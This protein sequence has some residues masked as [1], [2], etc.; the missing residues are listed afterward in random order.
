MP[1]AIR[2]FVAKILLALLCCAADFAKADFHI[3]R[4]AEIEEILTEIA[5]SVFKVA[6]INPESAKVYVVNS[7]DINAFTIGGG[8]VFVTSG[9][10]LRFKDPLYFLGVLCHETG[11]M[12]ARHIDR[13]IVALQNRS[14]NIMLAM[15][16]GLLGAVAGSQEAL[17]LALGYVVTDERFYLRYS[18]GDEFAADALGASYL[19]KLGYGSDVMIEVFSEFQRM[20]ILNGEASLPVYIRTHPKSNDR[21]SALQ[22]RAKSKKF[23]A[24]EELAKK[25]LRVLIKLNAYLKR[26]DVKTLVPT[27]D[28]SKAIYLH[29]IG[30]S[31]EA[32]DILRKLLKTNPNDF[33][34]QETLAQILYESGRLNESIAIYEKIYNKKVNALIKIDYANA[35]IEANKKLDFAISIL[36][37]AKYE[38]YFN[39]D[40]YRLLGKAY[41]KKKKEGLS[42]LL[43]AQEQMLLQN[44][45]SAY[46]LLI[47]SLRKFDKK[48]E[49]PQIKKAKYFIELVKRDYL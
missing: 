16:G 27:D 24:S 36:E 28:Y 2:G 45:R 15:L 48:T 42:L 18:R 9:L 4:D 37:T 25:Y 3:I 33:Y 21:I 10:L 20:E 23:R 43:L 46:E 47:V 6:G 26:F 5:Q 1:K 11:H 39:S 19:E 31:K 38:D 32:I 44:Y 12:A 40:I 34:C 35:L 13:H 22:K 29:R 17:A 14:K 41:G 30:R 7:D 49:Q 8:Y